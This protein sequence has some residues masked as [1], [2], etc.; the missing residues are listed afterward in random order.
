MRRPKRRP[1]LNENH[2]RELLE[3]H[4]VGSGG[5]YTQS[6]VRQLA[7]LMTGL[8]VDRSAAFIYQTN[9]VEPG[10]ETVLGVEYG[11]GRP[12]RLSE[13]EVTGGDQQEHNAIMGR[14][15]MAL[16]APV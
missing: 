14:S 6:D 3:L 16:G 12:P 15:M 9:R 5:A 13:I 11:G 4:T 10:A 1:G 8:M 2:A 7:E